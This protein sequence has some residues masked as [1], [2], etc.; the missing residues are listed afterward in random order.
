L[1]DIRFFSGGNNANGLDSG[2]AA[3]S[4][5]SPEFTPPAV[6]TSQ[7][8]DKLFKG[9]ALSFDCLASDLGEIYCS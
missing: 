2:V 7:M 3:G 5:N 4:L 8:A 9:T 6:E 1:P